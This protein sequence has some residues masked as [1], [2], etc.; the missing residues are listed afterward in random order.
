MPDLRDR[1]PALT[2]SVSQTSWISRG[3]APPLPG[4]TASPQKSW[5][6]A[7]VLQQ[8]AGRNHCKEAGEEEKPCPLRQAAMRAGAPSVSNR[9]SKQ[10]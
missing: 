3:I 4:P 1:N 5:L 8:Q 6:D 2:P 10:I 9:Q 7:N